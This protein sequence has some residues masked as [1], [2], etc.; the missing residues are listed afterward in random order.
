MQPKSPFAALKILHMALLGGMCL[1]AIVSLFL[2]REEFSAGLDRSA[3]TILQTVSAGAT[4]LCLLLGF[5]IFKKR[6]V[7]VHTSHEKAEKRLE[8][9]RKAIITWWAMIEAPGLLALV[10]FVLTSQYAFLALGLFHVA[11]LAIFMPRKM[12][13][14]L[15]LKL[16]AAEV[17]RLEKSG[18]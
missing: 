5:S 7:A 14:V 17:Q 2:P 16:T 6:L 10:G 3:E 11:L 12:N 1:V 15:L 13:I 9:Y 18:I 8:M 4:L